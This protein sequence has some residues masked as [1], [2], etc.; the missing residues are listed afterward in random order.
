MKAVLL[1]LILLA[2]GYSSTSPLQFQFGNNL[3]RFV[4]NQGVIPFYC[5]GGSGVYTFTFSNLPV[6]W[7]QN[8]NSIIVP[9]MNTLR[10]NY[11][12]RVYV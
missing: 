2:I 11:M 8:G 9:N 1:V 10:G 7:T 12:I 5:V 6:G 4:R 3:A